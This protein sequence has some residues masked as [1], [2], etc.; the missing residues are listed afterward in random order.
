[1]KKLGLND[2]LN[3]VECLIEFDML[4]LG[5]ELEIVYLLVKWK[6]FVLYEYGYEVGE[7]LYINM[8]VICRD[9]EFDVMYFIYVD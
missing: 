5:E 7:G 6:W 1:M 8:N 2:Y 9:E 3:G 4:Y